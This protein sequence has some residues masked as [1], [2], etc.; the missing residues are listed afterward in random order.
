M[1]AVIFALPGNESLA[2]RLAAIPG[3]EFGDCTFRRFPDGETAL[4]FRSPVRHRTVVLACTLD[5]PD[6]KLLRVYLAARTLRAMGATRVLLVAPYLPYMRQD[7]VFAPGE[8]I[9]ARHVADLLC[10]CVDGI[11]TVDP[12]LHRIAALEQIY[13]VPVEVVS[14]ADAIAAWI[15]AQVKNPVLIGP[16]EESE[17][18]VGA[19]AARIG[20]SY[21]VLRKQRQGD[22]SVAIDD[23]GLQLDAPCTPVLVDDIVASGGTLLELTRRLR[24]RQL[25]APVC[26]VV[27]GLF[28]N[29][30]LDML[31]AAGAAR[32]A[33]CSSVAHAAETID[34]GADL[35]GGLARLRGR[36]EAQ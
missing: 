36:C 34:L 3:Y 13:R 24:A 23:Q 18:W 28:V 30:A 22:R 5:H 11:V 10:S 35:S 16:D 15:R 25:P 7:T 2:E 33:A 6:D 12:H 20:C 21:Q 32:I 9:N 27:H 8:G 1:N 29:T 19:I 4:R 14:A 31:R 26:V 17:Q